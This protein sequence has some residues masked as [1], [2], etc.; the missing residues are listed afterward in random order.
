MK[1][2]TDGTSKI[3]TT[4]N[5]TK[6]S[7][8]VKGA[9]DLQRT[10]VLAEAPDFMMDLD[11]DA[12]ASD[13]T[14]KEFVALYEW[15]CEILK[16]LTE[17]SAD[18]VDS[19]DKELV[20][21]V[22]PDVLEHSLD[23]NTDKWDSKDTDARGKRRVVATKH[24]IETLFK[25]ET[26]L[27]CGMPDDAELVDFRYD[28]EKQSLEFVFSSKEWDSVNEATTIPRHDDA[29]GVGIEHGMEEL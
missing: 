24:F 8:S 17:L 11:E 25:S 2:R 9:S 5:G 3:V 27:V 14:E 15:Y 22:A 28:I 16:Q 10:R 19:M 7:F 13:L 29:M 26:A 21:K 18:N 1:R 23:N 12:Q 6:Y 4:H 20:V